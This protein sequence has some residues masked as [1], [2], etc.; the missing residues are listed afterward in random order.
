M[1]NFSNAEEA[2]LAEMNKYKSLFYNNSFKGMLE[3]KIFNYLYKVGFNVEEKGDHPKEIVTRYSVLKEENGDIHEVTCQK[4]CVDGSSDASR[5]IFIRKDGMKEQKVS[6]IE[7]GNNKKFFYDNFNEYFIYDRD[8]GVIA[9]VSEDGNR[10][11]Y[12]SIKDDS[13]YDVVDGCDIPFSKTKVSRGI[14]GKKI[15]ELLFKQEKIEIIKEAIISYKLE[16]SLKEKV[17]KSMLEEFRDI[18]EENP[19]EWEEEKIKK[20]IKK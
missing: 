5:V 10:K 13:Y 20:F 16:N 9:S 17:L 3:F 14:D 2:F 19:F 1:S 7:V 6:V 8:N 4:S 12:Y 11:Y 15:R 18:I